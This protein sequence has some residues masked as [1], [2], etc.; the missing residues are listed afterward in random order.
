[1]SKNDIEIDVVIGKPPDS[2]RVAK[3]VLAKKGDLYIS[4]FAPKVAGRKHS[5]HETGISHSYIDLLGGER[6]G[7][8]RPAGQKL[9]GMKGHLLVNAWGVPTVLEPTGYVAK[10]DTKIR[11]TLVTPKAE[12]GW[13]CYVW[14]IER[15]RK[16]L[17]EKI[18]HTDPWPEVPVVASLLADW[19]DPW[20]LVTIC[21]FITR[22]PYQVIE[23]APPLPG[24]IP[25]AFVPDAF[26]GTWLER[27]DN[28]WRPGEP[29]PK[30]WLRDAREY[31]AHQRAQE[32][33]R[34]RASSSED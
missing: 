1:M 14:A 13:Y 3:V 2:I 20:V 33:R 28:K 30:A 23:Y 9:R 8:G 11:R 25:F 24:Q 4:Q 34:A 26:E 10:T 5:Y 12:L 21:H 19:T 17:V 15:G 29:Y 6:I 22:E 27:P 31:L 32:E 18:S 7:E 16:D